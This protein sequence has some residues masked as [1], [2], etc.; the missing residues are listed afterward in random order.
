MGFWFGFNKS[1]QTPNLKPTLDDKM[2]DHYTY[3]HLEDFMLKKLKLLYNE[4][5]SKLVSLGYHDNVILDDALG[6]YH[7]RGNMYPLTNFLWI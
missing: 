2:L 4:A 7:W 5:I 1:T 6:N 3:E